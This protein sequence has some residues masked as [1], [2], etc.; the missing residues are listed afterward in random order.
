M[1]RVLFISNGHGEASIAERIA[2]ELPGFACATFE[3]L[4]LVWGGEGN[5]SLPLVGPRSAMPSG[6]LVAMGN[7]RAFSQDVR[8]GFFALFAEQ[9]RF[10]RTYGKGY[11]CVVAVGDVYA[12]A[13]ALFARSPVVFVGTAKSVLVAG[14]GPFERF[15]LRRAECVFVRDEPTA[16]ALRHRNVPAKAPGNTIVDLIDDEPPA[17]AG[18]WIGVLP[19]SRQQA[20]DAGVQLARVVRAMP[21]AALFSIAPGLHAAQFER[22]L[23][24]DGWRVT[25]TASD[26][27]SPFDAHDANGAHLLAWRGTL[28]SLLRASCLVIG[29]A[30]TA[31]EAAAACGVPIVA[32]ETD[33]GGWYRMRQQRL[34]GEALAIVPADPPAA[35]HALQALLND[36]ERLVHMSEVGRERMGKP[37]GAR[38]VAA[39]IARLCA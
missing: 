19:G 1:S 23:A 37:G 39:A 10:I 36:R 34:L 31:N 7:L 6:G 11:A 15:L 12:L 38:V 9:I 5:Q 32:L 24:A 18:T 4:P 17:R 8:A 22:C 16:L 33:S 30:G 26:R 13:L 25:Q 27:S 2:C 20:Y 3:H 14:Y 29:Q 21:A 35:A 28:G